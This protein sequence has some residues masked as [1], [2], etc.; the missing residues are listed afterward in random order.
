M[1]VFVGHHH[2]L[3][4]LLYV[5][6]SSFHC[7]IHF[8]S[9]KRRIVMLDFELSVKFHNYSIIEISY[10]VNDDSFR[11]TVTEDE[12]MFDEFGYNVLCD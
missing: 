8:R 4:N 1:P 12:V 2:L 10:V 6:L 9:V 11:D 7:A 5:F 3:H